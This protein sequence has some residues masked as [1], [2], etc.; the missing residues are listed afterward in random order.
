MDLI[1]R[2]KPIID[3]R[4][5]CVSPLWEQA[6][7]WVAEARVTVLLVLRQMPPVYAIRIHL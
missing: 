2:W 1:F 5:L 6:R 4:S 7:P 3:F